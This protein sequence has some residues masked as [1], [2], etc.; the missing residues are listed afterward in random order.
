[1]E[2]CHRPLRG[3]CTSF[4]V[5]VSFMTTKKDV[6]DQ[7]HNDVLHY[8]RPEI[9]DDN[10]LRIRNGRHYKHPTVNIGISTSPSVA[11][12]IN[13]GQ[14]LVLELDRIHQRLI[15]SACVA[16][17]PLPQEWKAVRTAMT[18]YSAAYAELIGIS[19]KLNSLIATEAP[20][21]LECNPPANNGIYGLVDSYGNSV[22]EV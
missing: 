18:D 14:Q 7:V 8:Q 5:Y 19:K 10:E 20:E 2:R 4:S 12:C 15:S 21:L 22:E 13:R 17:K 9:E 16:L 3:S 1:M 6:M 11:E